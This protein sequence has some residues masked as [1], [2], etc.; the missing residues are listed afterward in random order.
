MT[1]FAIE[2]SARSRGRWC[3][4]GT[5]WAEIEITAALLSCRERVIQIAYWVRWQLHLRRWKLVKRC[6]VLR[7]GSVERPIKPSK[8]TTKLLNDSSGSKRIR[9]EEAVRTIAAPMHG[10]VIAHAAQSLRR[11]R[12]LHRV[13]LIHD[14]GAVDPRLR[15]ERR[16]SR[17]RIGMGL[18]V[19]RSSGLPRS[20]ARSSL[21]P[22]M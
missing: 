10:A 1:A 18:L 13:E 19:T 8:A 4:V 15:I 21:S 5:A 3:A 22:K 2:A 17:G 16:R 12:S 9:A 14:A 20:Q 6:M 11:H 7:S